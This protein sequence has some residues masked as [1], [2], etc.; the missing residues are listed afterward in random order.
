V[1]YPEARK[2]TILY[3]N[4]KNK[5]AVKSLI[6]LVHQFL[7]SIVLVDWR[8]ETCSFKGNLFRENVCDT[9]VVLLWIVNQLVY[10]F[11]AGVSSYCW[12]FDKTLLRNNSVNSYR[13][14]L[15]DMLLSQSVARSTDEFRC[16]HDHNGARCATVLKDRV[17]RDW[18]EINFVHRQ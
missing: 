4:D 9:G 3:F 16:R 5:T 6:P 14:W 10:Q 1:L 7:K 12:D 2:F 8:E 18:H 13:K 17:Q 15:H 11:N